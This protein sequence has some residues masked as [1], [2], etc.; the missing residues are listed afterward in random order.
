MGYAVLLY[1]DDRTEQSIL[2]LRHALIEQGIP[3]ILD[4]AG[5]RPHVSLAGF[6]NVDC[7][8]LISLV[9]EYANGIEPFNVQLSSISTF[10][11]DEKVLFLS[12]TPTI[13]LLTVHQEFHQ[14]LAKSKLISSPYYVLENWVPHCSVE[15]NIPDDQFPKA[16]E[17][18]SK[19]FKPIRGQF[20]EI[21]VIEF[22]PIHQLGGFRLKEGFRNESS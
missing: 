8:I 18:C 6:S 13:Q 2:D 10:P 1:F 7:D 19:V 9:Q 12:P 16:I 3:S 22:P 20:Q 15:M 17:F 14:R 4:K 21:G 11:T 5:D